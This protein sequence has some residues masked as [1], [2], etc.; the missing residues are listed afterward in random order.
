MNFM[1]MML[2]YDQFDKLNAEFSRC[3]G[4]G[5]EFS[6]NFEQFRRRHQAISRSVHEADRFLKISNVAC[7]C[8]QIV[9]LILVF[10]STIFFREDILAVNLVSSLTY[11]AWMAFCVS[12]LSMTAGQAAVLNHRASILFLLLAKLLNLN[13][14]SRL[15]LPLRFEQKYSRFR[16]FS[17]M[18]VFYRVQN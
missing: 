16:R 4:D 12:G 13:A 1:V 14:Y 3:V 7:F 17:E 10:Y 18:C 8:F 15:Y 6:G 11:I 2:L 9:T 5:G